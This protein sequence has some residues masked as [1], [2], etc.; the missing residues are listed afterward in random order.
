MAGYSWCPPPAPHIHDIET[1]SGTKRLSKLASDHAEQQVSRAP[2]RVVD[3]KPGKSDS[4]DP[5]ACR[6][7]LVTLA[8]E[9]VWCGRLLGLSGSETSHGA[10]M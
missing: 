10:F 9:P 2:G 3:W 5:A 4:E 8:A 7:W 6:P 1:F